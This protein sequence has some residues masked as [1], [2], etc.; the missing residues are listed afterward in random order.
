MG[1]TSTASS[2]ASTSRST[3]S[4]SALEKG[5]GF[6]DVIFGWDIADRLYDNAA[7]TGWHSGYPDAHA[8]RS[9]REPPGSSATSPTPCTSSRTSGASD[10]KPHPACPRERP[11]ARRRSRR[12]QGLRADVLG[13]VR[14]LGV[15]RDARV[16]LVDKGHRDLTPL[17]PGMFGYSWVRSAQGASFV[18]DVLDTFAEYRIPDRG[19]SH[20]DRARG[21]RGRAR[22]TDALEAA[23]KCGALQDDDEAPRTSSRPRGDV[24]GEVEREAPRIERPS[25]REPL[26][27]AAREEPLLGPEGGARAQPARAAL[28]R[29]AGAPDAGAHRDLFADRQFVQALRAGR[30]GA[31][32]RDVGRR[33]PHVRRARD[34]RAWAERSARRVPA[35]RG[36]HQPV[37]RDGSVLGA[38]LL[39]DRARRSS[40]RR[41]P[42]GT[43]R[44]RTPRS[45][46]PRCALPSTPSKRATPRARS[47][48]RPSSTTTFERGTSSAASTSTRS[49]TGSSRAT[50]RPSEHALPPR[51]TAPLAAAPAVRPEAGRSVDLLVQRGTGRHRPRSRKARLGA[52]TETTAPASSTRSTRS[53]SQS[54]S[55]SVTSTTRRRERR[56][57]SGAA[58]SA[59]SRGCADSEKKRTLE[60]DLPAD[61]P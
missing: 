15:S 49:P 59:V 60:R 5:F 33:E 6:C 38:G 16:S 53:R 22:Y 43:P 29:W 48:A 54:P 44:P 26:G 14:V 4:A 51:K 39:R 57:A 17:S 52:S 61:E 19:V 46:R 21:V 2:G 12:G 20:R 9:I 34:Q 31:A 55:A 24:H 25:A 23:D 1:S 58:W 18:H 37:P 30:L 13:R 8:R 3:S 47:S 50:S 32:Q 40:P 36:R 7:V 42:R 10:G 41:P 27:L 11:Q 56:S 28:R 45:F 35:D